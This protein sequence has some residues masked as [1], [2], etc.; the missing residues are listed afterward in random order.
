MGAAESFS[1]YDDDESTDNKSTEQT[2]LLHNINRNKDIYVRNCEVK[3]MIKILN[4]Y[5]ID[6]LLQHY[7]KATHSDYIAIINENRD[8]VVQYFIN[9]HIN[10]STFCKQDKYQFVIN[11]VKYVKTI[12]KHVQM[13]NNNIDKVTQILYTLYRIIINY[14]SYLD[15]S[16]H[17]TG[18]D[19]VEQKNNM[20]NNMK[21]NMKKGNQNIYEKIATNNIN[22]KDKEIDGYDLSLFKKDIYENDCNK[23]LKC[24]L[25]NRLLHALK[26]CEMLDITTNTKHQQLFERFM[27]DT[28]YNLINDY[29]HFTEQHWHHI[30][31][32]KYNIL[33]TECSIMHINYFEENTKSALNPHLN[34]CKQTMD[35][36]HF[37]LYHSFMTGSRVDETFSNNEYI[38]PCERINKFISERKHIATSFD[39]FKVNNNNEYFDGEFKAIN[40][41]ISER[42][43]IA[44]S[45]DRFKVNHNNKFSIEVQNEHIKD[46]DDGATSF[47]RFKVNNNNEY[48]DV[49][50][51][52]VI[53]TFKY[54][55]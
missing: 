51:C 27:N 5:A 54:T 42:K 33:L 50:M 6:R 14:E 15:T 30:A 28:Y 2:L 8:K 25:L 36:L 4:N 53:I 47:D 12:D 45:F 35:S 38:P 31:E 18:K 17:E 43:H 55:S 37:Y 46:G 24:P 22:N 16:L 44:T 29:I 34:F 1:I 23:D 21:D 39:R 26:Y 11:V 41:F 32:I 20:K 10:G 13:N 3:E 52:T 40:R 19:I 9:N 48:F 7:Q 49:C